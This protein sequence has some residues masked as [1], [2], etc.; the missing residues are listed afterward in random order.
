MFPGL[1]RGAR[2]VPCI[3]L[4]SYH[5]RLACAGPERVPKTTAL[6]SVISS[7]GGGGNASS[8]DLAINSDGTVVA[9]TFA[10]TCGRCGRPGWCRA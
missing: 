8:A 5:H 9:F 1:S 4:S 3:S 7:G 6:V 2:V 10:R